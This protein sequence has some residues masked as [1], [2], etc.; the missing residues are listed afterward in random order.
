VQARS[1]FV[2]LPLPQNWAL[3]ATQTVDVI[4]GASPSY[5]TDPRTFT[6]MHDVRRAQ[7]VRLSWY[8]G[9]QKWSFGQ[10]YSEENDYLSKGVSLSFMQASSDRNVSVEAGFSRNEDTINPVNK[11][12]TDQHKSTQ[13]LLLSSTL[14]LTPS[15]IVQISWTLSSAKGYLSD[16]YKFFDVR[17]EHRQSHALSARWNHRLEAHDATVRLA[18]RFHQ[19]SFGVRSFM[20]QTEYSQAMGD[21]WY[22]TPLIRFYSQSQASFFSPPDP[23]KPTQPQIP[24]GVQLGITPLSFD[25]RLAA[26]GAVTAGIKIEKRLA[27]Q[28]TLDLRWDHYV[29]SNRWGVM[30]SGTQGLADFKVTMVQVGISHKF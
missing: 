5:Y 8:P 24:Q 30:Q 29:Q 21:G 18:T 15:D 19:D 25:Q 27:S 6:S 12:V 9:L 13:D 23:A 7:D 14:V 3:D 20:T 4:S 26:F 28:T 17:P 10:S 2:T 16:P 1:T 11:L 22:L